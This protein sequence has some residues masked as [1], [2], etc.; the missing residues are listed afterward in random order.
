[1]WTIKKNLITS[2]KNFV[3]LCLKEVG[4]TYFIRSREKLK[5][6]LKGTLFLEVLQ[7]TSTEDIPVMVCLFYWRNREAHQFFLDQIDHDGNSK[8]VSD[9]YDTIDRLISR[10]QELSSMVTSLEVEVNHYKNRCRLLSGRHY[11]FN[12]AVPSPRRNSSSSP[13]RND[14]YVS[15]LEN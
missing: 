5:N 14:Q 9:D 6:P 4:R 12:R 13:T 1:M 15:V 2:Q 8:A 10:N 3:T 7:Q 11:Q